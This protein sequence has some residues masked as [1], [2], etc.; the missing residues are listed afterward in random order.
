MLRVVWNAKTHV[1][2]TPCCRSSFSL[3][4]IDLGTSVR[5]LVH[6][7]SVASM[8]RH[9]N[10]NLSILQHEKVDEVLIQVNAMKILSALRLMVATASEVEAS[11]V[12]SRDPETL[13][14]MPPAGCTQ[15]ATPGSTGC[16]V[17]SILHFFLVL[18]FVVAHSDL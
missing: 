8:M 18:P 11:W 15:F 7:L 5:A 12:G 13:D 14:V 3:I 9:K 16:N 1:L 2:I 4:D 6:A 17:S 10:T